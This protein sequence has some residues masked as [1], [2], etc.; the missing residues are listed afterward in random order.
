MG[1]IIY[2]APYIPPV[3]AAPVWRGLRMSWTGWDGSEWALTSPRSGLFLM[4]GVRGLAFPK[5]ERYSS[6]PPGVAGSRH[7]GTRVDDREA[8]WP[9]YLY[10]DEGSQGFIDR[11]SAF[12]SSLHPDFEGRWTVEAPDGSTRSLGLRLKDVDDANPEAVFRGWAKYGIT[13]LA[14]HPYWEGEPVSRTWAQ[15]DMRAFLPPSAGAGFSV[16]SGSTLATAK[17]TNPGDVETHV[18]WEAHGPFT[19]VTVGVG[20]A[21]V[22]A[23]IQAAAGQVL[24]IDTD[25]EVQAA[26]LDWVDV[27]DRLTRAEFGTIQPG[28]AVPLT[29]AIA[30]TGF[31]TATYTPKY[32]RAWG[33]RQD[34]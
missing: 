9:L 4:P 13:L 30:G 26:F 34:A 1:G 29:L 21:T 20:D 2:G 16:S 10:S 5:F 18:V 11:D 24:V 12:W 17:A 22:V 27:T 8:F 19:S 7:R 33:R 32:F 25:P 28:A 14:D 6:S 15:A 31:I 3:P 23:P